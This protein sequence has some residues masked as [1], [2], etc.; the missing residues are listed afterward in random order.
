MEKKKEI[1][2]EIL[3]I[4]A[5][6]SVVLV[7]VAAQHF[8]D[9][10]VDTYTWKVSNI[11]HGAIRFAVPA[12]IM[13]SGYLYL[14]EKRE[15]SLSKLYK[16]N[17]IPVTVT[18]LFW[19]AFYAVYRVIMEGEVAFGSGDFFK[20][21]LI[22]FSKVYFHLWYMPMLIG[23]LILVPFIKVIVNGEG[24]KKRAEY[25]LIL[26]VIFQVLPVTIGYLPLPQQ[27][28]IKNIVNMIRPELVTSYV[29][30]FVLGHYLGT[31]EIP[32]KL[33]KWTYLSGSI[34]ILV[35]V[36]LCQWQSIRTGKAT[37]SFYENYTIANF[38][39]SAAVFLFCKNYLSKIQ[40]KDKMEKV[41]CHLGKCT[42]GIY[43][44]HALYRD[45]FY[46]MGIDSMSFNTAFAIPFV[47]LLILLCS[48]LTVVIIRKIPFLGKWIV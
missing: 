10:P 15:I 21:I 11:Y 36:Y 33:E 13:I 39:W 19:Q 48:W 28:Y 22:Y 8:R 5:C 32:K 2:I 29:G 6:V 31:Y 17:I 7:H 24:G 30:Y 12:F 1:W 45:I 38:L 43:L 41:I 26:H 14:N 9:I 34:L 23:L 37:Q 16:K 40:W 35:A 4:M 3:R 25:L 20:R 27:E 44:L 47:A 42:F 46:R 18:F